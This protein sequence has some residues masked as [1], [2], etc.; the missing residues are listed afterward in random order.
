MKELTSLEGK[1]RK[2]NIIEEVGSE[3]YNVGI[4]VVLL[5]DTKGAKMKGIIEKC[6][7]DPVQI[8]REIMSKW[9]QGGGIEDRSWQGLIGVLRENSLQALAEDI[10]EVKGKN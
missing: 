2:I 1:K 8:S 6:R 3:Y 4:H 5:N 7:G 10:E 9:L